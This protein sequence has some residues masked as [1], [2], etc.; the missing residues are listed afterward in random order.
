MILCQEILSKY[1]SENG[2]AQNLINEKNCAHLKALKY[3]TPYPNH[4]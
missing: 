4:Y 1:I 2:S 3:P